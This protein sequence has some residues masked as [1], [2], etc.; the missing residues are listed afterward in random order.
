MNINWGYKILIAIL[1]F[2]TLMGTLVYK[3]IHT[4]YELVSDTYYKEELVYQKQ[5]DGT[6]RVQSL[7][8]SLRVNETAQF[9]EVQLP[10]AMKGKTIK[11]DLTF[12]CPTSA[13]N[14]TS[15]SI[16]VDSAAIQRI[17]ALS[18]KKGLYVVKA[19][20]EAGGDYYYGEKNI[21]H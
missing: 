11:G 10:H 18:L 20:W 2:I 21:I 14:D 4:Q 3:S 13:A 15:F 5:I 8:D 16:M 7:K 6:K 19:S 12:Y 17:P 9:I 1:V